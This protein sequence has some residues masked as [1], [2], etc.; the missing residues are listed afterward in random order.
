MKEI[1]ETKTVQSDNCPNYEAYYDECLK[2]KAE[3]EILRD[4]IVKLVIE[5]YQEK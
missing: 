2:L 1:G 4:I 5:K 3:N